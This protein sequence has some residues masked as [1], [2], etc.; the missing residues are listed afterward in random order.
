MVVAV[1]Q[2]Y[3][4]LPEGQEHKSLFKPR[5]QTPRMDNVRGFLM[6]KIRIYILFRPTPKNR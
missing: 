4:Y 5:N 3:Q 1:I 2:G 6:L